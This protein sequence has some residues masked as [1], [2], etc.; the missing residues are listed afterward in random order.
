MVSDINFDNRIF[1]Y[2]RI[3]NDLTASQLAQDFGVSHT[4]ILQI[5]KGEKKPSQR[6]LSLYSKKFGVS[7]RLLIAFTS[8]IKNKEK[9]STLNSKEIL[10]L[11]LKKMCNEKDI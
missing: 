8:E 6:L 1:K 4:T 3:A 11:I 5:E 9:K 2:V 7:E 10:L